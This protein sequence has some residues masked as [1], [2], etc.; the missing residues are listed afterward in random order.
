[1][2]GHPQGGHYDDGYGQNQGQG[3][4]QQGHDAYYQDDQY[5]Q[6]HDDARGNQ[7]QYQQHGDAYYDEAYVSSPHLHLPEI[8]TNRISEATTMASKVANTNKMVIMMIA[9]SRATRTSITMINTMT[10]V[11][12][13]MDMLK[14][15]S[16]MFP[17]RPAKLRI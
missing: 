2:S 15:G 9:V 8:I 14:T 13:K 5:G 7:G 4:H 12:T 16:F 1:M 3:Q 11:A 17:V 10:R 6:Y